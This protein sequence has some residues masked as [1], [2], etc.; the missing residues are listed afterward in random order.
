MG[1]NLLIMKLSIS[2]T[3]SATNLYV[4]KSFREGKKTSSKIVEKLGTYEE[5]EKKLNGIDPIEWAKA[6][7]KDLNEK[8]KEDRKD[9]NIR[10]S[11]ST[12]IEMG[13]SQSFNVGYLF[14]QQIYYELGLNKICKCIDY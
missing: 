2:K 10:F 3:K 4:S 14:L 13:E 1:F 9:V 6:Y 12:T 8:E 5:L 11:P 7:I